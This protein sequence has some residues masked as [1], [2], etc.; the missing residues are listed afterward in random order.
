MVFEPFSNRRFLL[1]RE[2]TR[3]ILLIQDIGIHLVFFGDH[4]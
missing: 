1:V 4:D 2:L 3:K